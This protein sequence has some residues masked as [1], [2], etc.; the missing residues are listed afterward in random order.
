MRAIKEHGLRDRHH[1]PT[2]SL[3]C[4]RNRDKTKPFM[5]F[6]QHKAP[7][8][9][10]EPALRHLASDG[11]RKYAE[12][13]RFRRKTMPGRGLAEHDQDMTIDKTMNERDLS[14][15]LADAHS[16]AAQGSGTP[17][18]SRAIRVFRAAKARG[19]RVRAWN[20]SAYMH[21]YLATLRAVDERCRPRARLLEASRV[22]PKTRS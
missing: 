1:P 14:L 20:I 10:W 8:R 6:S 13:L 9:E 11:D 3:D 15:S 22:S 4:L 7:A 17:T 19:K 12:H 5:R 18:T 21:D 16:G 2:R